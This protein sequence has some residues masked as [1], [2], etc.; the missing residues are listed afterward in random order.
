MATVGSLAIRVSA[1][2]EGLSQGLNKAS[3]ML[4]SFAAS[5]KNTFGGLLAFDVFGRLTHGLQSIVTDAFRSIDAINDLSERT[6]AST[7]FIS[8]LEHAANL[9]GST[10][11]DVQMALDKLNKKMGEARVSKSVA[12]DFE[13]LGISADRLASMGLQETFIEVAEKISQLG[14]EQERAAA[15]AA[16]FDKASSK[17]LNTLRSGAAGIEAA[18]IETERLGTSIDQATAENVA[19]AADGWDR[20]KASISGV[21]RQLS[22]EIGEVHAALSAVGDLIPETG[23][24]PFSLADAISPFGRIIR[25]VRQFMGIDVQQIRERTNRGPDQFA[26]LSNQ[27]SPLFSGIK[28]AFTDALERMRE[29]TK[30]AEKIKEDLMTPAERFRET[31][32]LLNKLKEGGFITPELFGRGLKRAMQ[33]FEKAEEMT[34]KLKEAREVVEFQAPAA[35]GRGTQEALSIIARHERSGLMGGGKEKVQMEIRD[36]V[37]RVAELQKQTVLNLGK[38]LTIAAEGGIGLVRF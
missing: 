24:K 14:T 27:V 4:N 37:Q 7:Q 31:L 26:L 13:R 5:A 12:A 19:R 28:G 2:T 8:A 35:V 9:S 18:R 23:L 36:G 30:L 25:D 22:S 29:M 21:G 3:G 17:M 15:A 32:D 16:I 34:E 20:F 6:G 33:D 1:S 10:F 11:E 38:M